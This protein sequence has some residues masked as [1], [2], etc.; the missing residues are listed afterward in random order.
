MQLSG[1]ATG[2]IHGIPIR[3]VGFEKL[4]YMILSVTKRPVI[5]GRSPIWE[6]S[7]WQIYTFGYNPSR[8]E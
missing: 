2:E 6:S 1:N 8:N 5:G 7:P 3:V 4:P